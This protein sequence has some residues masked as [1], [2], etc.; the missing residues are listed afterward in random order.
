MLK[1]KSTPRNPKDFRDSRKE[2]VVT[3]FGKLVMS[4]DDWEELDE[5]AACEIHSCLPKNVLTNIHGTYSTKE[6]LE[7]LEELF[8]AKSICN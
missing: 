5:R 2:A 6:F 3:S 1:G 4:N 8:Q 7:R